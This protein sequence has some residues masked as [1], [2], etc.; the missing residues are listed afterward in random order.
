MTPDP[1]FD[2]IHRHLTT[3]KVL[4]A[5]NLVLVVALMILTAMLL[6]RIR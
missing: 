6:G 4:V 1:L 2:R 5:I 3:V